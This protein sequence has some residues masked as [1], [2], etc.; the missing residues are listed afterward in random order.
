MFRVTNKS[1]DL[2]E[3]LLYEDIGEGFLG[4]VSAKQFREVVSEATGNSVLNVR[5]NSA[6][7]DIFDGFAMYN[8][9]RESP[10]KVEVDIDGLAASAASVVAMAGDVVRMAD[11]ARMMIHNAWTVTAGDYRE[12]RRVADLLE[13]INGDIVDAYHSRVDLP[14]DA[15]V[16]MLDAETWM[17][18]EEARDMG[19]VD[20]VAEGLSVAAAWV[21]RRRYRNTPR[22][23]IEQPEP[24][25]ESFRASSLARKRLLTSRGW[26]S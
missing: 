24:V 12:L 19:F 6:G 22:E 9:L 16:E 7:G 2:V 18:A 21:D 8:A 1:D 5:I 17:D 14:R 20:Q 15:L 25:V 4:G 3:I 10:N 26:R 23:L 13:S 11:N